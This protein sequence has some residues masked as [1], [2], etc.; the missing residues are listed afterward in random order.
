VIR[1]V[2]DELVVDCDPENGTCVRMVK[3]RSR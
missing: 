1:E 2:M 3:R